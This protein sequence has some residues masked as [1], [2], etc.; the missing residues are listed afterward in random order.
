MERK[1]HPC[2]VFRI[3]KMERKKTIDVLTLELSKWKEN[4]KHPCVVFKLT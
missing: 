4:K 3:K 2:V 1:K